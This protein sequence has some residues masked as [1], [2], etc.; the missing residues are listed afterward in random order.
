[1]IKKFSSES[2]FFV[3]SGLSIIFFLLLILVP[4]TFVLSYPI[5][6]WQNT[7]AVFLNPEMMSLIFDSLSFSFKVAFWVTTIDLLLGLPVAWVLARH[8][9]FGKSII[10]SLFKLPLTVP[11]SALGFSVVFFWTQ[12][13]T[14]LPAFLLVTLVHL[15]FSFPYITTSMAIVLAEVSRSPEEAA[16]TLGASV[17]TATRTITLP[18]VRKGIAS[19]TIFTF[20]RSLSETGATI[21][22]LAT[23]GSALK[24]APVLIAS[25]KKASSMTEFVAAAAVVSAILIVLSCLLFS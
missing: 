20:A 25:W 14:P 22:A 18:L 2:L 21:I 15:A 17:M 5:R 23:V 19:A 9:F 8:N 12:I 6:N 10:D 13:N 7:R 11:T 4:S 3:L 24:T 16:R 1:M